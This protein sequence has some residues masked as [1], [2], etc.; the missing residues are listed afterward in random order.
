MAEHPYLIGIDP[1]V[2]GAIVV[3]TGDASRILSIR[4]MPVVECRGKRHV[5]PRQLAHLLDPDEE[6]ALA[7]V[8]HVQGVQQS[9]ATSAFNFGRGFGVI[10]GVIAGLGLPCELVRPQVWTKALRV[11]RDK[12]SH[13]EAAMRLWP[14]QADKF[15][16]VKDDGRGRRG[17][18]VPLVRDGAGEGGG[19]TPTKEEL[20]AVRF[21]ATYG[22][23]LPLSTATVTAMQSLLAKLEN[24]R[25]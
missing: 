24:T 7:I 9:G 1:G 17:V 4:D 8:E 5:C 10:E 2:S 12:G 25:E 15:S 21:I 13:R 18:A 22:G 3:T 6:Q 20:D 23:S 19:M 16:R 11:S 14:D